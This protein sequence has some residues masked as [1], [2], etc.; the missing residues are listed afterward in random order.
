MPTY[1]YKCKECGKVFEIFRHFSEL[2]EEVICPNCDSK[3]TE[4]IFSIP[5]IRGETVAGSGYG[6]KSSSAHTMPKSEQGQG[7]ESG[8]GRGRRWRKN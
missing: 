8:M 3:N 4:R 5:N 6:I 1:D 7:Q 2:E